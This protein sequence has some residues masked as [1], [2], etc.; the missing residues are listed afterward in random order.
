MM[1][2]LHFRRERSITRCLD[3]VN[4]VKQYTRA[5]I[6]PTSNTHF[7]IYC[8]KSLVSTIKRFLDLEMV[9]CSHHQCYRCKRTW[10]PVKIT[11]KLFFIRLFLIASNT[12]KKLSCSPR[13]N[14]NFNLL[15]LMALRLFPN[16]RF[17]NRPNPNWSP[18]LYRVP[19]IILSPPQSWIR[20]PGYTL[21]EW[22][23]V[24]EKSDLMH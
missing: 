8:G 7:I 15:T 13:W 12:G 11:Q 9:Y 20:D 17:P 4:R 21:R 16:A 2:D 14:S 6:G 22:L 23:E 3:K 18:T 19:N 10:S 1:E 24:V 5:M